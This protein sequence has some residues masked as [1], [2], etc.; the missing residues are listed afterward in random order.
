MTGTGTGIRVV[1]HDGLIAFSTKVTD[2]TLTMQKQNKKEMMNDI[3][4]QN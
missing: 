1:E 2:K 3:L 4:L